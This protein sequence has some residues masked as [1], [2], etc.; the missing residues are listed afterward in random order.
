M[1]RAVGSSGVGDVKRRLSQKTAVAERAGVDGINASG[2]SAA[3]GSG[4]HLRVSLYTTVLDGTA[5]AHDPTGT[6][7]KIQIWGGSQTSLC[8]WQGFK[9]VGESE[10]LLY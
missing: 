1:A 3:A 5:A 10:T 4:D 8:T 7:S 9:L 2:Q 6:K